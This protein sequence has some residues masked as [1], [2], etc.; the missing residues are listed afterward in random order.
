[1][2]IFCHAF[3]AVLLSSGDKLECAYYSDTGKVGVIAVFGTS[4][5]LANSY[6]LK[7]VRKSP[8]I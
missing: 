7:S 5:T 3:K 2:V 6:Y 1:M 4:L 8:L